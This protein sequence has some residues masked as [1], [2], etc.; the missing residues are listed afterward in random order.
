MPDDRL[1][2]LRE[3]MES[4]SPPQ[5]AALEQALRQR[6][7]K[8][9]V[10][11]A[12]PAPK[13]RT[14]RATSTM[15]FSLF[16]FSGDGSK[17]GADNYRLLLDSAQ[18][19]DREG[20][21]AIWVPERHFVDFGGLYPNPSVL[22]A[23]LAVTT[24][25]VQIRAGSVAVPLHHPVRIAEEWSV[26]DNLSGG[27]VAIACASGWHPDDFVI[28][29]NGRAGHK[30]RKD[31]MFDA[32]DLVQRLWAGETVD[33]DGVA[34]RTLP[35]PRQPRLPLWISSQGSV[36]T[37][38][39]AG[40][41]GANVLTG[42]VAMRPADL[43]DK[44]DAYREAL[45][46]AGHTDGVVTAMVHT[47]L[48]ADEDEVREL[49]RDPLIGYLRTFLAQQGS[50]DSEFNLLDDEGREAMLA[51]SFDRYFESLALLGTPDKAESLVEDLVDLGVDEV[52]CLV[53]FGLEPEVVLDGLRH[54]AELKDRYRG[55]R[56]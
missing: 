9:P 23:A 14:R 8:P 31:D 1:R 15:E 16:F 37:F 43:K 38:V 49:V 50:F 19:A 6:D 28:A 11:T 41:I 7:A 35:R 10:P 53:D 29:P 54:L 17:A 21:S 46:E 39:R 24:E 34:V 5:R 12:R 47:F 40:R 26:V 13:R 30:S 52:A 22:A 51:A 42:L 32:I 3:R 44:I 20:F 36:D 2:Q 55:A 18:V 25:R 48:G 4:L 45:A 33:V 56:S 27:R